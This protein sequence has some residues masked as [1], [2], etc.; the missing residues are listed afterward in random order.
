MKPPTPANENERIAA[1]RE[2]DILDSLPEQA[3]DDITALAAHLCGTPLAVITLVDENRQWFKSQF[4]LDV[5]ETP[6]DLSFCAHAILETDLFE[7]ADA[8]RDLRFSDHPGVLDSPRLRFYAGAPLVTSEGHALGTLCVADTVPRRLTD[9]QQKSLRALARQV[10]AQLDLRR[11]VARLEKLLEERDRMER[12]VLERAESGLRYHAVLVELAR[13]DKSDVDEALRTI[14]QRDAETLGVTRVGVWLF[15]DEGR[16]LVCRSVYD[17]REGT[18]TGGPSLP[19]ADYPRYFAAMGEQRVIAAHDA[20]NDPRT[21][22][23][24]DS[25]LAPLGITAMLDV[26]IWREGRVVGIVCHEHAGGARRWTG[27]EQDFAVSVADMVSLALEAGERAR[28]EAALRESEASYR[29]IFDLSNDAIYIHDPETGAV[30]DV[31]RKACEETGYTR[32]ELPKLELGALSARDEG[33]TRE[34]LLQYFARASS[35]EP[36]R[37]EWLERARDGRRMWKEITLR[38][39][40]INGQDRLLAT[41]RDISEQK[42]AAEELRRAHEDLERRVV[43]RTAELAR[44]NAALHD[45]IRERQ[46]AEAELQR[47]GEEVRRREEH[48]RALAEH[49]SDIASILDFEGLA[50]YESPSIERILGYRPDELRGQR[51]FDYVHPD[52]REQ[53]VAA[54]RDLVETGTPRPVEF[55][56]R[57]RDGRWRVLEGIGRLLP[58]DSPVPGVIVNSRDVTERR[59]AE[60]ALQFAIREAQE[61]RESAERA[62]RAKSE[63]LSR[64]SHEL[65]T[66]MNS[67]LGF[68]QLLGRKDLPVDQRRAVEHILKAG[69]HLLNL[70]NEVLDI[71]RIETDRQ[72]FSLEPVPVAPALRET[73]NLI[74]PLAA[75]RDCH[76]DEDIACAGGYHVLAD[77]QRLMQVLLNLMSN[78]VKYNRP[79]GSIGFS[80]EATE[81]EGGVGSKAML[82]ISVHDTGQGI[83]SDKFEQLFT[84]FERLGAEQLDVEGTG[85]G[86]ALSKRLVEAMNGQIDVRSAPGE[87]STFTVALPL[88]ESPLE[89]LQ[90]NGAGPDDVR[91]EHPAR[92]ARIL[93]IEDNLANLSLIETI[94]AGRTGIE[95]IPALQGQLGLDLA[96][97]HVPDL[98]LLDVH[99]PDL[100]G[101]EVLGR[102]RSDSRTARTPVVVISADAMPGRSERLLQRGAQAYLTKPLDVQLFLDT[103]DRLLGERGR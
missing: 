43:E 97:E 70:I 18:H 32:E 102:L 54:F 30:V 21:S 103:V 24:R 7:V 27:E 5:A 38:R 44:V 68:A 69:R 20:Q 6:R 93:Y 56:F 39:V 86:L 77:R 82:R 65:R 9:Q 11:N 12:E 66:P 67:I 55:R 85:L 8:T 37:F 62:N 90:A 61:A 50:L 51:V 34:R 58:V 84:P 41:A 25:Y 26:P 64:M 45:E 94:F 92:T 81:A 47:S 98:I 76:I 17:T 74:R 100:S 80:C 78:A 57:H 28:A 63:F 15:A 4:G 71:A 53:T 29:A 60:E 35:G 89:R 91:T 23:F 14:T 87:G 88:A 75:Q 59:R 40:L 73:L 49:S 95:L 72:T 1:L 16:T 101:V 10:M 31:N 22:E 2:Y 36:Q 52:D 42:R 96:W 33:Y 3:Y 13:L 99:L 46:R 48:F 19:A 79:G 83:P